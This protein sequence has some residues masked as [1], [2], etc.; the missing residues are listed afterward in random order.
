[1]ENFFDSF[2]DLEIEDAKS[3]SDIQKPVCSKVFFKKFYQNFKKIQGY[4]A[5]DNSDEWFLNANPDSIEGLDKRD[6]LNSLASYYYSKG[7]YDLA[8]KVSLFKY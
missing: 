1:M 5:L 7:K 2:G 6:F 3:P 8:Y 4:K